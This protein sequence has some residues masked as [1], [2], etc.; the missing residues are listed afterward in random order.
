L[1][2]QWGDNNAIPQHLTPLISHPDDEVFV[3]AAWTASVLTWRDGDDPHLPE[4]F[5]LTAIQRLS[6]LL[7]HHKEHVVICAL[8]SIADARCLDNVLVDFLLEIADEGGVDHV[9]KLMGSSNLHVA[10]AALLVIHRIQCIDFDTGPAR[11][12]VLR[13]FLKHGVIQALL[14]NLSCNSSRLFQQTA[15]V[16]DDFWHMME[17]PLAAST[18]LHLIRLL[19]SLENLARL[20]VIS[21]M[22]DAIQFG[23]DFT[24]LDPS[25]PRLLL[26]LARDEMNSFDFFKQ[27]LQL[28]YFFIKDHSELREP[29]RAAG[30]ESFLADPQLLSRLTELGEDG[31]HVRKQIQGSLDLL[32]DLDSNS[33]E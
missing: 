12:P 9:I 13:H 11:H 7:H 30:A 33:S 17:S 16:I 15:D 28:I 8:H 10:E 18:M 6:R 26:Q 19:L 22:N 4:S 31:D 3:E 23:V 21:F 29:F 25:I 24:H 2:D 5:P 27:I 20:V 32:R 14:H 1:K